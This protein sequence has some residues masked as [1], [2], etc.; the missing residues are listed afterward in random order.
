MVGTMWSSDLATTPGAFQTTFG[1]N[2]DG[3]VV[4]INTTGSAA[5]YSSYL[6]G[7]NAEDATGVA[8]DAAGNA[9]V[10]GS[11]N[12]ATFPT[13]T[14]GVVQPT[15]TSGFNGFVLKLNPAG[16]SLLFA[17]FV[18]NAGDGIPWAMDLDSAGNIFLG[19]YSNP[20]VPLVNN[21]QTS[22]G[23]LDGYVAALN[24]TATAYL[25]SSPLGGAGNDRV[26][27]V[28]ADGAG[29]FW[30]VGSKDSTAF[31]TQTPFQAT[32]GGGTQDLFIAK[33]STA[34]ST[35]GATISQSGGTTSVTEGGA[36]D[37]Y[38]VVLNLAPTAD[39]TITLNPGT[40]V[41]ATPATLTFTAANWNV[42]QTVTVTAVDDALVE[43]VHTGTI[44]HTSASADAAYNAI[45]IASITVNITD[46]DSVAPPVI[47]PP[48]P[49]GGLNE[50][51]YAGSQGSGSSGEGAFGFGR[52]A[53]RLSRPMLK[54][55]Y[56]D[57]QGTFRVF[58]AAHQQQ[59]SSPGDEGGLGIVAWG[60]LILSVLAPAALV[61]GRRRPA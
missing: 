22:S 29:N 52:H 9:Y 21:F 40:Q 13:T 1:G 10:C 45:V 56:R 33:I 24:P 30:A 23:G 2:Y 25:L 16:S 42:A 17:T 37:S 61:F 46:N 49:G 28:A 11:S 57:P 39:V 14:P 44:T 34:A 53:G 48:V 4:K 50:G 18:G 26:L 31:P 19:G 41:T 6:G 47:P 20:G 43:G 32:L 38:T 60:L 12:T 35:T 54:G 36:T 27:G 55:P 8:V 59:V 51:N 5:D 15:S 58:N 3:F 7:A